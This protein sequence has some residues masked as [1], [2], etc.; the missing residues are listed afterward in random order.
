MTVHTMRFYC[1]FERAPAERAPEESYEVGPSGRSS[2]RTEGGV[3]SHNDPPMATPSYIYIYIYICIYI[4]IYIYTHICL[5]AQHPRV[6]RHLRERRADGGRGVLVCNSFMSLTLKLIQ[7]TSNSLNVQC[8]LIYDKV[9]L[10]III[11]S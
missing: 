1:F 4:Y 6:R 2:A 3:S 5:S 11:S 10:A 8:S 7:T 9:V